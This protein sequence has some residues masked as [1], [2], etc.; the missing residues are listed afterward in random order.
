MRTM[1]N[2]DDE[3]N[4]RMIKKLD[5]I[6]IDVTIIKAQLSQLNKTVLGN[7]QLPVESRLTRLETEIDQIQSQSAKSWQFFVAIGA[8]I[9]S[10]ILSFIL[11]VLA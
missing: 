6:Q 10:I 8:A 7:G 1:D 5:E 4:A 11:K 9:S 3:A 2:H